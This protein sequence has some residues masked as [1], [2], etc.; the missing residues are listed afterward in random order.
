[1]SEPDDVSPIDAPINHEGRRGFLPIDT[2]LFDRF[3]IGVISHVALNLLW[4]RFLEPHG[5][6]LIIGTV[7]GI[8]WIGVVMKWG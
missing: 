4:M 5:V 8:L 3:F 1:M 6:P 7:L 2:N